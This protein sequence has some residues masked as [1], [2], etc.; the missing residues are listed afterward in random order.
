MDDRK[1]MSLDLRLVSV[2]AQIY[3]TIVKKKNNKK[4]NKHELGNVLLFFT[5]LINPLIKSVFW[6][7]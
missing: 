6:Y 7:H 5:E 2:F 4:R 1:L 3:L